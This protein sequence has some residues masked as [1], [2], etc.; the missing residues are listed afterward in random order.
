[1]CSERNVLR[2]FFFVVDEICLDFFDVLFEIALNVKKY[3]RFVLR[4]DVKIFFEIS[5][6]LNSEG[7]INKIFVLNGIVLI[8]YFIN[9]SLSLLFVSIR[10]VG[11]DNSFFGSFIG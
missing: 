11:S 4:L 9:C 6:V 2:L 10:I 1:M 3:L 7:V 5:V 8:D